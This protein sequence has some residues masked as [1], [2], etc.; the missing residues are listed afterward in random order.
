MAKRRKKVVHEA[1]QIKTGRIQYLTAN[2]LLYLE[3][4]F[5]QFNCPFSWK[6]KFLNLR[7]TISPWQRGNV[8]TLGLTQKGLKKAFQSLKSRWKIFKD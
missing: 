4:L 7:T 3:N 2:I 6:Y 8:M 1:R 5:G